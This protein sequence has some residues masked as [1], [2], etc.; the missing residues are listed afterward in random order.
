M[1]L[2]AI[3]QRVLGGDDKGS[4]ATISWATGIG[5]T[6]GVYVSGGVSGQYNNLAVFY[7]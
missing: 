3:A 6:L 2:M 7:N 1:S 4:Q 5:V